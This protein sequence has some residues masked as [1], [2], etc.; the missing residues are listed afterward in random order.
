LTNIG[1]V[2]EDL[3]RQLTEHGFNSREEIAE[4]DA[5]EL[6]DQLDIT[7]VKA[8]RIVAAAGE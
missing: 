3:A 4:V 6:A 2:N 7:S 5:E 1:G 8:A